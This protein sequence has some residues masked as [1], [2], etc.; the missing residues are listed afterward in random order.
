M[1]IVTNCKKVKV[2]AHAT[3]HTRPGDHSR[4]TPPRKKENHF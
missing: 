2:A 4:R 3:R 1:V